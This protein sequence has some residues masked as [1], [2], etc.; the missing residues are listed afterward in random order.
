MNQVKNFFNNTFKLYG[1]MFVEE[2]SK[3]DL[4]TK[5]LRGIT[6]IFLS[7]YIYTTGRDEIPEN[8][9]DLL[10]YYDLEI[11]QERT[12]NFSQ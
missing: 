11:D 10:L 12:P 4:M 1:Q 3:G 9:P 6:P 5:F 8:D 2:N 7:S